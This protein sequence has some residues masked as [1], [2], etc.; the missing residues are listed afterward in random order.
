MASGGVQ[1][2]GQDLFFHLKSPVISNFV[3]SF[4]SSYAVSDAWNDI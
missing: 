2:F 3:F 1:L 4:A